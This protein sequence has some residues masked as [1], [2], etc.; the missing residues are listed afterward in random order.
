MHAS[1]NSQSGSRIKLAM[2]ASRRQM[3][4]GTHMHAS[5]WAHLPVNGK[6]LMHVDIMYH[7]S[8]T[9]PMAA[10]RPS[11]VVHWPPKDHAMRGLADTR[12]HNGQV[13]LRVTTH[14]AA[15]ERALP[16]ELSAPIERGSRALNEGAARA[17]E[18]GATPRSLASGR[19]A[20]VGWRR[21]RRPSSLPTAL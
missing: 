4:M 7:T 20:A 19:S 1:A 13:G 3:Q 14:R 9:N 2:H 11:G 12:S 6:W 15:S 17:R 16:N 10:H 5:E 21:R 18:A 8:R